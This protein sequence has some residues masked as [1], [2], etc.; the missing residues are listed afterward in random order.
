MYI[1]HHVKPLPV[2]SSISSSCLGQFPF[3]CV[4]VCICSAS[5]RPFDKISLELDPEYIIIFPFATMGGCSNQLVI[6]QAMFDTL[7][8]HLLGPASPV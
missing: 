6:K 8:L 7:L 1:Q 4:S 5:L 3:L 2:Y